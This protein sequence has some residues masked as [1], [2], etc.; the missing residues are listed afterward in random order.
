MPMLRKQL[1]EITEADLHAICEEQWLEDEQID[2]KQMMPHKEGEG[3][4]PWRDQRVIKDHGRD[5]LLATVVAFANSYGG[6]LVIGVG[7]EESSQPGRAEAIAAVAACEDAAHRL[8]QMARSCIDPPLPNLQVRGIKVN[9]DGS[10]VVIL[11]T[12]QSRAAPHRLTT[13]HGAMKECFHRVRHETVAMTMRQIQDLTF[14]V[15]R[16][17]D[18]VERRFAVARDSSERWARVDIPTEQLQR[19]SIRVT[20]VPASGDVYLEKVHNVEQIRPQQRSAR[21]RLRAEGEPFRLVPP[22]GVNQWRPVLRG[23]EAESRRPDSRARVGV[24]CD[25]TINYDFSFD[26][27]VAQDGPEPRGRQRT[28]VLYP[29]WHF[30]ILVNAIEAAHR[31]RVAA[32]AS[33]VDYGME[34]EITTSHDLPVLRFNDQGWPDA[35]GTLPVGPRIFPR[36]V[37][38]P[39]DTWRDTY[40]LIFRDFW[41]S[42]GID[43]SADDFLLDAQ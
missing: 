22:F 11:R 13:V 30:S 37:I 8:A 40:N 14:S 24:Y 15:S 33:M 18:L 4:D 42:I 6:D 25:G 20:A 39:T 5:Q 34:V 23:S 9:E 31:F 38:G 36:Y 27:A 7:E 28:F 17:L 3:K 41:N 12:Q 10:G 16:G 19:F 21:V 1:T 35:A 32:G 43:T 2:F 26:V 29:G